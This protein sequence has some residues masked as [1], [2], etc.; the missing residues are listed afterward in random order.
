MQLQYR[1]ATSRG[2]ETTFS[3][4]TFRT[5]TD[6]IT[7]FPTGKVTLKTPSVLEKRPGHVL[8]FQDAAPFVVISAWG[9]FPAQDV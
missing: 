2:A 9:P 4:P 8:M 6:F 5:F 3:V 1:C 7:N